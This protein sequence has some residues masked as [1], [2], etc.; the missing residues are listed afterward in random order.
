MSQQNHETA[1]VLLQRAD[2]GTDPHNPL[3]ND[4]S[5]P[6]VVVSLG[7]FNHIKTLSGASGPLRR[8]PTPVVVLEPERQHAKHV[9]L[10]LSVSQTEVRET[11]RK[12]K[13]DRQEEGEL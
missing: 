4:I 1:L 5:L 3:T 8:L 6:N 10:L 7:T 11:E 13:R 9:S 12:E 2:Q